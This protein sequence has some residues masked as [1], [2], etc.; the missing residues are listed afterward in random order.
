MANTAPSSD[1]ILSSPYVWC[2]SVSMVSTA[3]VFLIISVSHVPVVT[4]VDSPTVNQCHSFCGLS[5]CLHFEFSFCITIWR[6]GSLSPAW[7][8]PRVR[9]VTRRARQSVVQSDSSCFLSSYHAT[10]PHQ[11]GPHSASFFCTG[12]KT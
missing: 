4:C 8:R 12:V 5:I 10:P 11:T 2:V 7:A 9:Q 1:L 6:G 3:F